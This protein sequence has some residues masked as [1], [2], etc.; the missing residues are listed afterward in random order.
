MITE[1]WWIG[2]V[3]L[4]QKTTSP[5]PSIASAR[6]PM[7]SFE[8]MVTIASRVGIEVDV[9]ARR[10]QSQI[11]SAQL[12]DAAR[13]RV[14]VV[15]RLLHRLDQLL[16]DV[17]RRRPVGVP[18]REVDDVLAGAARRELQVADDVED[19]RREPFDARKVHA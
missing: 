12:V 1:Y 4:G 5:G 19:V 11:A 6:W 13:H 18:H 15:D 7:P 2:Y 9:V 10:Y 16:H 8:P 14:A 17:R 3:G